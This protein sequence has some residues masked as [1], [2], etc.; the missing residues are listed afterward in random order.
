V[1]PTA[2]GCNSV[3]VEVKLR[4]NKPGGRQQQQQLRWTSTRG[5]WQE[6]SSN[7]KREETFLSGH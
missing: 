3:E 6:L 5:K 1:V 2:N 7:L 4:R